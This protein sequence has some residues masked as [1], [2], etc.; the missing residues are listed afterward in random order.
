MAAV[1]EV[2]G[3]GVPESA[4][5]P[6]D[7]QVLVDHLTRLLQATLEATDDDLRRPESIFGS[8]LIEQTL[9]RCA[10]FAQEAQAASLYIQKL[11]LY[12]SSQDDGSSANGLCLQSRIF[13]C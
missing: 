8:V 9:Q 3:N 4:A 5:P 12:S 1:T 10:S 13:L 11:L 7:V 2:N 6:I